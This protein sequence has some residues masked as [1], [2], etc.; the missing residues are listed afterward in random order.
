M[1]FSGA[2]R[3]DLLNWQ[4]RKQKTGKLRLTAGKSDSSDLRH[5]GLRAYLTAVDDTTPGERYYSDLE[6]DATWAGHDL[7]DFTVPQLPH[8][9][10]TGREGETQRRLLR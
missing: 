8:L 3:E 7:A 1:L 4:L 10:Q 5:L 9:K 6:A 2:C